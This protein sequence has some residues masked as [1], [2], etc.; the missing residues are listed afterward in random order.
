MGQISDFLDDDD[1]RRE[2][3]SAGAPQAATPQPATP[4]AAPP[5]SA[6]Q[7]ESEISRFLAD[8][9]PPERGLK[10]WAQDIGATAVKAAI[11]VPETAVGLA[12]LA[13]GGRAGRAA[14]GLG[15]RFKEA[16]EIAN[17]WHSEATK[18]AQRQYQQAEGVTGKAAAALRNPS[19][20]AT[21]VG[22]SLPSMFTG[23]LIGRGLML[24]GRMGPALAGALGEGIVGAGSAAEQIR[25]ESPNGLLAGRQA[26]LAGLSGAATAGFGLLGGKMA[27]RW[28]ASDLETMLAGAGRAAAK[29]AAQPVAKGLPRQMAQGALSEGVLEELP[30]SV[31][32]QALQNIA[33][34]RPW[35]E[36]VDSAA[37]LG[38]LTGGVMGAGASGLHG[39]RSRP[40]A[41]EPLKPSQRMGLDAHAGQ[42]SA[43]AVVAVDSGASPAALTAAA[44]QGAQPGAL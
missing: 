16:R 1:K 27:Q 28:G 23:G 2:A 37:V 17:D 7:P 18:E 41:P 26:G 38:T 25:Q 32:E 24:A 14:E 34:D 36:D 31:T 20:I 15:L 30:Q 5:A 42:L 10:G 11:A 39:L 43:A 44:Q 9:P 4:P 22:E 13:T 21:A 19:V 8:A 40:A 35:Q 3:A 6:A 33:L 12:D 29:P